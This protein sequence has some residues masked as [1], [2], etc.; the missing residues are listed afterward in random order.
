MTDAAALVRLTM[1]GPCD[2]MEVYSWFDNNT[3]A[4]M[5]FCRRHARIKMDSRFGK[6]R[7]EAVPQSS[8]PS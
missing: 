2:P 8:S 3:E 6:A 7:L 4:Y 5:A 1:V